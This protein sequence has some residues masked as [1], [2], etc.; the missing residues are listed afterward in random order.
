MAILDKEFAGYSIE[1]ARD[2]EGKRRAQKREGRILEMLPQSRIT[3]KEL[4]GWFESGMEAETELTEMARARGKTRKG[5]SRGYF[6]RGRS[7]LKAFNA[8]F[9]DPAPAMV[10]HRRQGRPDPAP[11]YCHQEQ[12][13]ACDPA[14][15]A[16][17]GSSG[18]PASSFAWLR[19]HIQGEALDRLGR[20]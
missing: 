8:T 16:G 7:A 15:A 12:A 2:A 19:Y 14:I 6:N 18:R 11:R 3:F 13:A 5:P 4:S 1:E 20:S 9:G 10:F 17:A